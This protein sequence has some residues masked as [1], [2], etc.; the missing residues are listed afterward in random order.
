MMVGV[1][2]NTVVMEEVWHK[3]ILNLNAGILGF[4]FFWRK[5]VLHGNKRNWHFPHQFFLKN[6]INLVKF[7]C[8]F[9]TIQWY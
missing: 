1:L 6:K 9:A 5:K 2:G 7:E 3:T 4:F 8:K